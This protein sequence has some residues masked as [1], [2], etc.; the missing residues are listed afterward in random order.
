MSSSAVIKPVI[1][2]DKPAL[3]I[4]AVLGFPEYLAMAAPVATLMLKISKLLKSSSF[5]AS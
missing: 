3:M 5:F 2:C 4:P 1:P